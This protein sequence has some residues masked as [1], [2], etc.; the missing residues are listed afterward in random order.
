MAVPNSLNEPEVSPPNAVE[1]VVVITIH[2]VS[3][4]ESAHYQDVAL[5][6][7]KMPAEGEP[8]TIQH[9]EILEIDSVSAEEER[10]DSTLLN[11]PAIFI[12]QPKGVNIDSTQEIEH[13]PPP[14]PTSLQGTSISPPPERTSKLS[15]ISFISNVSP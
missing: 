1:P 14:T 11:G 7:A 2:E 12:N 9:D 15:E 4:N 10:P 3:S 6:E 5:M 8:C 13:K